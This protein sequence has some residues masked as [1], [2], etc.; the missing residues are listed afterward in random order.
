[1]STPW[2]STMSNTEAVADAPGLSLVGTKVVAMVLT[3]LVPILLGLIPWKVG[4]YV[5][6]DNIRHQ[7]VVSC[8]LCF[9]GGILIGLSLLHMLPEVSNRHLLVSLH[10]SKQVKPSSFT[11]D[12]PTGWRKKPS[13]VI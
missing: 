8:L 13:Q 3:G 4:K 1:M 5:N 9:G 2:I 10:L 11:E 6:A 12:Q 7:I